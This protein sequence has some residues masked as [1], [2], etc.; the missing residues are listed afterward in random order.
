MVSQATVIVLQAL[1]RN[2]QNGSFV[3]RATAALVML[4]RS[5]VPFASESICCSVFDN[6]IS[7][8]HWHASNP[9]LVA[10]ICSAF[11]EMILSFPPT[12]DDGKKTMLSV[13]PRLHMAHEFLN[14]L[15]DTLPFI[16]E[17][18]ALLDCVARE[19]VIPTSSKSPTASSTSS[20]PHFNC[21]A[22]SF[23]PGVP[24]NR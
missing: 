20:L 21:N 18:R 13:M 1:H 22:A 19:C 23:T 6:C 12:S 17:A 15:V 16:P 24:F 5:D 8:L 4:L 2:E 7:A 9:A 14:N 11:R 3:R 10:C